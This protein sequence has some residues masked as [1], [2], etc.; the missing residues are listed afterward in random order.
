MDN[1]IFK[2]VTT[3]HQNVCSIAIS[4]Y[5]DNGGQPFEQ[6]VEIITLNMTSW[7]GYLSRNRWLECDATTHHNLLLTDRQKFIKSFREHKE[8]RE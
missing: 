4:F 2:P 1:L 3:F 6:E 5:V 8:N 7:K